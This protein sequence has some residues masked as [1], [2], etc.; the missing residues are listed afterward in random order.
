MKGLTVFTV[1]GLALGVS[2][3]SLMGQGTTTSLET[4]KVVAQA[5]EKVITIPGDLTPYQAV[6][7]NARVSGFVESMAVDRGSFVKRGQALARISAPELRAQHAEADAKLQ[8]VRAQE[9]EAEAKTVAAQSTYDRLKAAS[10]TPAITAGIVPTTI[11]ATL[12]DWKYAARSRKMATMASPRPERRPSSVCCMGA[13]CPRTLTVTP[14]GGSPARD[15]A[16]N[17]SSEAVPRSSPCTFAV[18]VIIRCWL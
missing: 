15:T 14:A 12:S 3:A 5:L 1:C 16:A 17:T 13:T 6:N 11:N 10:A 18:S 4:T 7:L 2:A 9:A 8:G